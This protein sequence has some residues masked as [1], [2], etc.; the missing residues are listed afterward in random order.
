[1]SGGPLRSSLV[2]A[3]LAKNSLHICS[4]RQPVGSIPE[5]GFVFN[6]TTT[7]NGGYVAFIPYEIG[8]GANREV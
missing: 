2:S 3:L 4:L 6:T 8:D 5:R 1:M 7:L